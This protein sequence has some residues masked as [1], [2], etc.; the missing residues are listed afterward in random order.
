MCLLVYWF[1]LCPTEGVRKPLLSNKVFLRLKKVFR[2]KKASKKPPETFWEPIFSL[3]RFRIPPPFYAHPLC[4]SSP[5][6]S[7]EL[8]SSNARG[9]F[10]QT[11]AP[12][13]D[14][15]PAPMGA[16]I[17]SSWSGVWHPHGE[18]S[19]PPNTHTGWKPASQRSSKTTCVCTMICSP[20]AGP[21]AAWSW[22]RESSWGEEAWCEGKLWN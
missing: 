1:F 16:R 21:Q 18:R 4:T 9:A 10:L 14:K 6:S 12:M 8:E 20:L 17:L 13:L 15:N 5:L 3:R 7:R 19:T 11:P 22:A 2:R